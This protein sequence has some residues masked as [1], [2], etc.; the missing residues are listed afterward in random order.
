[1]CWVWLVPLITGKACHRRPSLGVIFESVTDGHGLALIGVLVSGVNA[2]GNPGL[3]A[4]KRA[5]GISVVWQ[6]EP[7]EVTFT[8]QQ[9]LLPVAIHSVSDV[10]KLIDFSNVLNPSA[11]VTC[12]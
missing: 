8:P 2:N 11:S 5:G 10:Q 3:E 6:P 1:M 9:A 4:L 7:A 12:R